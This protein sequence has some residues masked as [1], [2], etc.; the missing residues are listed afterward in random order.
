MVC[1]S[2]QAPAVF[3]AM[4]SHTSVCLPLLWGWGAGPPQPQSS[5]A[6]SA[7]S[8]TL[9]GGTGRFQK[10]S[11]LLISAVSLNGA[12]GPAG[13]CTRTVGELENLGPAC[14]GLPSSIGTNTLLLSVLHLL[15]FPIAPEPPE[16][17]PH[18]G[19]RWLQ[20]LEGCWAPWMCSVGKC[21]RMSLGPGEEGPGGTRPCS[22][23]GPLAQI[24]APTAPFLR[25]LLSGRSPRPARG[26]DH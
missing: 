2:G 24:S 1:D 20:S 26:R 22:V 8:H 15:V 14:H 17:G 19:H 6:I 23:K 10:A 11:S 12:Q 7:P 5:K 4:P 25:V 16:A 18:L 21:H 3:T 9:Q 13:P